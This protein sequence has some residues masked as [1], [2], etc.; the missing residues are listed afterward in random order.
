MRFQVDMT[1]PNTHKITLEKI[2]LEK[3]KYETHDHA[4]TTVT[5]NYQPNTDTN[6]TN[7]IPPIAILVSVTATDEK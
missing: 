6:A 4:N 1:N 3:V 7:L 2:L 5:N